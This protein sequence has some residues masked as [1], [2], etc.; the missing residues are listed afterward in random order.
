MSFR[1]VGTITPQ[2]LIQHILPSKVR[3]Y[4]NYNFIIPGRKIGSLLYSR[5]LLVWRAVIQ[6]EQPAK[7]AKSNVGNHS[8]CIYNIYT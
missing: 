6:K 7:V 8:S 3:N 1:Y 5:E 2:I 4:G